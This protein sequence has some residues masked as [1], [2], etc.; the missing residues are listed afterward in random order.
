MLKLS[1]YDEQ[2]FILDRVKVDDHF[3][4]VEYTQ[5]TRNKKFLMKIL[6][7]RTEFAKKSAQAMAAKMYNDL[8]I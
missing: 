7:L 8:P 4:K 2:E 6:K 1:Q 3:T 5:H